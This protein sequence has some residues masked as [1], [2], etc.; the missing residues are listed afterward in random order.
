[1]RLQ[2]KCISLVGACLAIS[3]A[4]AS[5]QSDYSPGEGAVVSKVSYYADDD[6]TTVLTTIV[7]GE[8]QLPVVTVGAHMLLDAVS[9][10]SVDVVAS[11][12]GRWT[13][14]RV[15]SGLRAS[16]SLAAIDVSLG[17]VASREEDWASNSVQATLGRELFQR[18][19]RVQVGYGVTLNDVGRAHDP[20]FLDKLNV[21][22][23]EAGV[24]QLIDTRTLVGLTA[25]L[26]LSSGY[27]ASPYRYVAT[28]T[29]FAG[30]EI[31]PDSRQRRAV[32]LRGIRA[33]GSRTSVD[34]DYRL[35]SDDW[36]IMSH[37]FT[38]AL[39]VEVSELLDIRARA[40][41]YYQNAAVFFQEE[42][43][44]PAMYMTSDRELG[45]FWDAGGGLRLLLHIRSLTIDGKVEGIYYKFLDFAP[46]PQ[47]TAL[48][49]SLGLNWPW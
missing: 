49:T 4:T 48:I 14:N 17:V 19:T 13:E 25:T 12:T 24:T 34:A 43:A 23:V 30:P 10:A 22:T 8:V 28:T 37:T 1:M 27:H 6:A 20:T 47:R 26:Q 44:T 33:L 35:Y 39:H 45:T 38:T 7:D 11:A 46:L 9:S 36:G 41:G 31:H 42:Y 40:R 18:N 32:T 2:L 16:A 3:A 29:G 5:A 21:H 15:E